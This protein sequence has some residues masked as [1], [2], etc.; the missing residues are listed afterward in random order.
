[1]DRLAV[2]AKPRLGALLRLKGAMHIYEVTPGALNSKVSE[3][4]QEVTL[5]KT[6]CTSQP[7]RHIERFVA[8]DRV[9]QYIVDPGLL[10]IVT[11]LSKDMLG[12]KVLATRKV[13]AKAG[14]KGVVAHIDGYGVRIMMYFDEAAEDTIVVWDCLYG[15][16]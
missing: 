10:P 12:R 5:N 1:M 13:G 2:L 16:M 8:E 6:K 15:V 11:A 14:D 7:Y 9:M 3:D 4:G